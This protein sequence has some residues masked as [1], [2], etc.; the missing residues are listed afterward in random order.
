MS[1]KST[2]S[3][4]IML[5]MLHSE[6][7]YYFNF[8]I[9][10]VLSQRATQALTGIMLRKNLWFCATFLYYLHDAHLPKWFKP[11]LIFGF[12]Q[13]SFGC[14][15]NPKLHNVTWLYILRVTVSGCCL[16]AVQLNIITNK[17]GTC[18]VLNPDYYDLG[19]VEVE[20]WLA[21]RSKRRR[22]WEADIKCV[23]SEAANMVRPRCQRHRDRSANTAPFGAEN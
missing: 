13:S 23:D 16:F 9:I 18:T 14:R 6:W 11:R 21:R 4:Y 5:F 12:E 20:V 2:H 17:Y 15:K 8:T 10:T 1:S 22:R 19:G 3:C 7:W